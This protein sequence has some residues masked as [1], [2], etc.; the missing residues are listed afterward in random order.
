MWPENSY[1]FSLEL[2][3]AEEQ[4][5]IFITKGFTW[6][7]KRADDNKQKVAYTTQLFY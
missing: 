6:T 3:L 5:T 4:E 1:H 2:Q 7:C